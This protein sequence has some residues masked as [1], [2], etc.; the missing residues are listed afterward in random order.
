MVR[1]NI[2]DPKRLA[3]QHL[4]AE[5][6]EI[7]ML[8][9]HVRKFPKVYD[10]P[11]DYCLGKGHIKFFKNKLIYIKKR[12]EKIKK[13]MRKR[14]FKANK[15]IKLDF[16][17]EL[18]NDWKPKDKGCIKKRLIEKIKK[19][20]NYYRYYGEKKSSGFFIKLIKDK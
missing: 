5:Y 11:K 14:G 12:H 15:T 19:K 17:K 1:I 3:D 13:E 16:K 20:P 18:L 4:I 2:I 10:I 6:N 9:G 8:I 7:L